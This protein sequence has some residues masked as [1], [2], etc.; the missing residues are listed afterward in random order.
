MA[1]IAIPKRKIKAE[2]SSKTPT[3]TDTVCVFE[4]PRLRCPSGN[5]T[6][7]GEDNDVAVR[8]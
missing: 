2:A 8:C 1:G 7:H 6:H 4:D 5:R 3:A